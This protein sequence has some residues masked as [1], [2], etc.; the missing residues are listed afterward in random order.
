[1]ASESEAP[2]M[3]A[4]PSQEKLEENKVIES[5]QTQ[6]DFDQPADSSRQQED[7]SKASQK[8]PPK[9]GIPPKRLSTAN[10]RPVAP[11]PA[12]MSKTNAL[13]NS[14][15]AP[16]SGL[17]K[18]PTR[19]PASSS[20]RRPATNLAGTTSHKKSSSINSLDRTSKGDPSALDENT[21]PTN[22]KTD[23]KRYGTGRGE[24]LQANDNPSQDKVRQ[25]QTVGVAQNTNSPT[26]KSVPRSTPNP[27]LS[28]G[29]IPPRNSRPKVSSPKRNAVG[30]EAPR[31]R[32]S[33]IPASPAPIQSASI[34]SASAVQPPSATVRAARPA[35]G[36]RKSTTSMTIEQRLREMDAVH[37]MLRIAMAEEGDENDEVKEDFGKVD[38]SLAS[39]RTRIEEVRRNEGFV[40]PKAED[41][42]GGL[43]SQDISPSEKTQPV[44]SIPELQ[45]ALSE[46]Q[47]K[48]SLP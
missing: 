47:A 17:S 48:V 5:A 3:E 43:S 9:K 21:Q 2:A 44:A 18:P 45:E 42:T 10:K 26:S 25:G 36:P 16:G 46:S 33:T 34:P 19:P 12:S 14:R 13:S 22:G 6:Q 39:L 1:M 38:E 31:K 24:P 7:S 4:L 40:H 27:R 37:Q 32:L 23:V 15:N 29:G 30:N 35:L 20:A 8:S 41:G 11:T 28:G